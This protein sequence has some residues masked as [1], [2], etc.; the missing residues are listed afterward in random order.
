MPKGK[1]I[2]DDDD[3]DQRKSVEWGPTDQGG[4]G[5]AASREHAPDVPENT[6]E[7]PD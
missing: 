5:G 4:Q 3:R 7:P 6:E 2:Y 1:G